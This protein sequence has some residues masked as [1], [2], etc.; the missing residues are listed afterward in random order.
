MF[1]YFASFKKVSYAIVN[2]RNFQV[3]ATD[4]PAYMHVFLVHVSLC[5]SILKTL[6]LD[7]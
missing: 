1:L 4:L 5:F 6:F 2:F 3:D 7:T